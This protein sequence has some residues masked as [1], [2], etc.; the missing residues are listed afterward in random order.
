[1]VC[2]FRTWRH[3]D[4][5]GRVTALTCVRAV[6]HHDRH[7]L[8]QSVTITPENYSGTISIESFTE[9]P[10]PGDTMVFQGGGRG[11]R[12]READGQG[13]DDRHGIS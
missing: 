11:S 1:M 12:D 5:Q 2:F 4:E 8:L 7:L 10:Q 13:N 6:C 3:E 9:G